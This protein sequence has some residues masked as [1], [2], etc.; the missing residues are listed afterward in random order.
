MKRGNFE[1]IAYDRRTDNNTGDL[2]ECCNCEE[3]MLV[4]RGTEDCPLCEKKGCLKW[5]DYDYEEWDGTE[6]NLTLIGYRSY[7]HR[8]R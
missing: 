5:A 8:S 7:N 1:Y 6:E 2:V 3:I 4:D